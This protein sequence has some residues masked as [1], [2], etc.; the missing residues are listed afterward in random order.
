MPFIHVSVEI[1]HNNGI[2]L[3]LHV[4]EVCRLIHLCTLDILFV[5]DETYFPQTGGVP[6][7]SPLEPVLEDIFMGFVEYKI[8]DRLPTVTVYKRY[9]D[10]IFVIANPE[11]EI[12]SLHSKI[13]NMHPNIR[14]AIEM[15]KEKILPLLDVLYI[16]NSD[17]MM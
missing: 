1:T 3:E 14:S 13:D 16:W 9:V 17:G 6:V 10:C 12:K 7:G 4:Y 11:N 5:F 15:E 2:S 8:V